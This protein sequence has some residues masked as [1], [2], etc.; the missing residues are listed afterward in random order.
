MN[1]KQS[2][3]GSSIAFIVATSCCWL[4]ALIIAIGGGA[5]LMGISNGIEKF[6]GLFI[7]IGVLF[8]GIGVY[9]FNKRKNSMMN[10]AAI[11]Q[12]TIT[13][14][15]CGHKKEETMPTDA[16]QFF[17]NVRSVKKCSSLREMIVVSIVATVQ[18]LARLFNQIKIVAETAEGF[19]SLQQPYSIGPDRLRRALQSQRPIHPFT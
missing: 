18:C 13:C 7:T 3:V 10:K 9:Q 8:L 17:M 19:K 6:S 16:C 15:E 14:P 2:I 12:S 11:L 5:T 4:P 1:Y